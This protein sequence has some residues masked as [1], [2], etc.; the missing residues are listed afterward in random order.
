MDHIHPGQPWR[1]Q[2]YGCPVCPARFPTIHDK[3]A[4]MRA[5]HP[6]ERDARP[7]R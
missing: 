1:S 3:K 7:A 2:R 6:K 5:E 4:H